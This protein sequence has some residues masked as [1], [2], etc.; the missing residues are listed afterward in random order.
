MGNSPVK[1][2]PIF[3]PK[4]LHVDL[5][6]EISVIKNNDRQKKF[7]SST[8]NTCHQ[9]IEYMPKDDQNH[10]VSFLNSKIDA[11]KELNL[12]DGLNNISPKDKQKTDKIEKISPKKINHVDQEKNKHSKKHPKIFKNEKPIH[13]KRKQFSCKNVIKRKFGHINDFEEKPNNHKIS[14]PISSKEDFHSHHNLNFHHHKKHDKNNKNHHYKKVCSLST[15]KS[16][17]SNYDQELINNNESKQKNDID[18]IVIIRSILIEMG[19]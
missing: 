13:T 7:S 17:V 9:E 4:S 2:T 18:S 12:D 1:T 5:A 3:D 11:L 14:D 8:L 6:T 16:K 15:I 19:N 10:F